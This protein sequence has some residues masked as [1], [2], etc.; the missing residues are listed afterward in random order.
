[1]D[2]MKISRREFVRTGLCAACGAALFPLALARAE[3]EFSVGDPHV[4]VGITAGD[5]G[6]HG[7][8]GGYARR[9][10]LGYETSCATECR[11]GQRDRTCGDACE[12]RGGGGFTHFVSHD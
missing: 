9:R 1:M 8:V 3:E 4:K 11:R 12:Q 6:A 10:R 7:A 5:G 2:G